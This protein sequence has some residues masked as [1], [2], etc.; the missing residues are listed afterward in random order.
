MIVFGMA[1][2]PALL[3]FTYSAGFMKRFLPFSVIKLQR[4]A[5]LMVALIM[6]WRGIVFSWPDILPGEPV[7]C[8]SKEMV[9][10]N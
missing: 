1:T 8:H 10:I 4:V 6:I 9:T 5:L 3:A 7:I 2:I